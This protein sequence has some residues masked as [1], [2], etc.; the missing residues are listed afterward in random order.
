M[1]DLRRRVVASP[2]VAEGMV[3]PEYGGRGVP[4]IVPALCGPAR[5]G[6]RPDWFP[7]S[8]RGAKQAVLLVLDGLGWDQLKDLRS[9]TPTMAKM[10]GGPITTVAPSTTATALTSIATG[11]TPGEHGIV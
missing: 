4:G 5:L 6:D 11:L 2:P 1:D 3:L 7:A 8:A 9:R 10:D